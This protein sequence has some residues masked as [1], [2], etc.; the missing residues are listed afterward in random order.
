MGE[1][2]RT[3]TLDVLLKDLDASTLA[4]L[5]EALPDASKRELAL[6][7][8]QLCSLVRASVSKRTFRSGSD[9]LL[10][11][12]PAR[13]VEQFPNCTEVRCLPCSAL[14]ISCHLPAIL[15]A[16][17]CYQPALK[18]LW[19][20]PVNAVEGVSAVGNLRLASLLLPALQSLRFADDRFCKYA[21]ATLGNFRNLTRLELA[22]SSRVSPMLDAMEE[23]S[24]LQQ[25]KVLHSGDPSFA[26]YGSP[27]LPSVAVQD[28]SFVTALTKL[29]SLSICITGSLDPLASCTSLECLALQT[30]EFG[31]DHGA[32]EAYRTERNAWLESSPFSY[33][34]L[35]SLSRLTSLGMT[36]EADL[37]PLWSRSS[38]CEL[39]LFGLQLPSAPSLSSLSCLTRLDTA[40]C[41]D[42]PM[43]S[44][45]LAA[46]LPH[47]Q[48][49]R[50]INMNHFTEEHLHALRSS[51]GLTCLG[52]HWSSQGPLNM[53][54]MPTVL[55]LKVCHSSSPGD[56]LLPVAAFPGLTSYAETVGLTAA[57]VLK[58]LTQ[59]CK[60][61]R[62]VRIEGVYNY[63]DGD[64][65]IS[66]AALES[67]KELPALRTLSLGVYSRRE[68]HIIS[69][70]TQI[71]ELVLGFYLPDENL[72]GEAFSQQGLL[73]SLRNLRSLRKLSVLRP[74]FL[75]PMG[76]RNL[77]LAWPCLEV[78]EL[79]DARAA[80]AKQ[81][82]ADAVNDLY[83]RG[84]RRVRLREQ[85][86]EDGE[87]LIVAYD[88]PGAA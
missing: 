24:A 66:S 57:P 13:L 75:T 51:S 2:I 63:S 46:A 9:P 18:I 54:Q 87:A 45:S 58:G 30:P 26:Q 20:Q 79:V 83:G 49:L 41:Q 62:E 64:Q 23:L 27:E 55:R 72:L 36:A 19:L 73:L 33:T 68:M 12:K 59:H 47:L 22:C 34:F 67:L 32:M 8:K 28:C 40:G 15:E 42:S 21:L 29:T 70:V 7:C 16:A 5:I 43:F 61:L 31:S 3:G 69:S 81:H 35:L 44:S 86:S 77:V 76:A 48:Q 10:A 78:L 71:T 80:W 60:Q 38:L 1:S 85:L 4:P 17:A 39:A 6:S 84:L 50:E 56:P 53:M 74:P 82:F 14:D 25:L 52:G 65:M 37:Q 88:W 11:G